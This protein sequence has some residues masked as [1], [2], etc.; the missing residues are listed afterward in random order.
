[1]LSFFLSWWK[2]VPKVWKKVPKV[3]KKV[4]GTFFH[5]LKKKLNKNI[6]FNGKNCI[7]SGGFGPRILILPQKKKKKITT[8]LAESHVFLSM[9]VIVILH[10]FGSIYYCI[11]KIRNFLFF[12]G[13]IEMRGPN[14]PEFMQFFPIEIN[15]FVELFF[16]CGQESTCYFL[17]RCLVLSSPLLVLSCPALKKLNK[18]IKLEGNQV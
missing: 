8:F 2:K 11:W 13:K 9:K 12:R 1:M 15:I 14:P 17:A 3:W 7:N 4:P 10:Y 18:N 5:Q 6:D 16:K